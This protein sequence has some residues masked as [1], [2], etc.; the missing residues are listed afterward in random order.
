MCDSF[1]TS[2][3]NL[4]SD[5]SQFCISSFALR[6]WGLSFQLVIYSPNKALSA[7]LC[8][9]MCLV[10]YLSSEVL[11]EKGSNVFPA[12]V[13]SSK[14]AAFEKSV[15]AQSS[16]KTET[17][18]LSNLVDILTSK[19]SKKT[20]LNKTCVIFSTDLKER[21]RLNWRLHTKKLGEKHTFYIFLRC[22]WKIRPHISHVSLQRNML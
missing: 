12:L 6:L 18:V 21:T 9:C 5:Y 2:T 22:K 17:V 1:I 8:L 7:P 20:F 13:S 19:S 11:R 14:G 16:L 15:E 3:I 4:F 10:K